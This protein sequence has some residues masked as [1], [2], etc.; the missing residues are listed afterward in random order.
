MQTRKDLLQA[1]RLS[2]QRASLALILGQPDN[3]ELPMRR[4]NVSTFAGVMITVLVMAV[5][6]IFGILRPGGATNLRQ[7]GMLIIEKET[8][9]R[10]VWCEDGKLCPV[11]NYVSARLMAGADSK[12][13][14]TVSRN[15][16][17]DFPRG[18]LIGISGAPNTLPDAKQ[19]VR[20]PWSACVRA[21][22]N[23]TLGHV[24]TVSLVVGSQVGGRSLRD[25]QAV[26]IRSADQP[27]LIWKNRRLRVDPDVV[28][29][30]DP[31]PAQI[32]GKWLNALPAG[33]D[34]RAPAIPALGQ[35][36]TGPG[37]RPA[38]VGQLYSVV[39]GSNTNYYVQ[40]AD[41]IAP[42]SEI[43]K[44]LL[45]ADPDS[46]RAYGDLPVQEGQ[47]DP[48]TI[49]TTPKSVRQVTNPELAGRPPQIVSYSDRTPLC[50]VYDDPSGNSGGRVTLDGALPDPPQTVAAV[51]VDQLVFPPG[52]AALV[53]AM[54][55]P[56]KAAAIRNHYLVTEGMRFALKD[57]ETAG[58][59]GYDVSRA[60]PVPTSLLNLI[61]EGP[62]LDPD[63][64]ARELSAGP[65]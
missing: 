10:Y 35:E 37:G 48:A 60:V 2:T 64:A 57:A 61:P 15:S 19:L 65:R 3:P 22:D 52:G 44:E 31:N 28:T 43:E 59:L 14:R 7:A 62:V 9:A 8:G 13:R 45:R 38:K 27:W 11:A 23:A 18:P 40:L 17:D 12:S 30:L 55:A 4:I 54:S 32:S 56:G 47:L 5:F 39:I 29:A 42:I 26:L 33:P 46:R 25:D 58:K 50:S 36:V 34:Y 51:G 1:H 16:L 24:S 53:G 20:T 21:V 49:N 6:G 63:A 41:G